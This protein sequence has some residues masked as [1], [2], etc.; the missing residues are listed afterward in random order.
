MLY[1]ERIRSTL[2]QKNAYLR[3]LTISWPLEGAEAGKGF[4]SVV[5]DG[6][7]PGTVVLSIR[8]DIFTDEQETRLAERG[9]EL[10]ED[11]QTILIKVYAFELQG[12]FEIADLVTFVEWVFLTIQEAAVDYEPR[13]RSLGEEKGDGCGSSCK[14]SAQVIIA[15]AAVLL[16]LAM[17]LWK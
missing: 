11:D 15:I 5:M 1:A 13:V 7:E 6:Q 9:F 12:Q 17:L 2:R 4:T 10:T 14:S 8:S 16:V 3:H